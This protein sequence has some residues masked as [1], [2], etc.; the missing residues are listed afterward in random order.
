M[1]FSFSIMKTLWLPGAGLWGTYLFII[2][3]RVDA[4]NYTR[5]NRS[6]LS[7]LS[8]LV[9]LHCSSW[10]FN[11]NA[12]CFGPAKLGL[13]PDRN[14][15]T[16]RQNG[17]LKQWV[18]QT[19]ETR[20]NLWEVNTPQTHRKQLTHIILINAIR[21]HSRTLDRWLEWQKTSTG[22]VEMHTTK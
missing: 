11:G 6:F 14:I 22:R 9:P 15:L 5:L 19:K 1:G 13:L 20:H 10:M 18:L 2:D 21:Y 3:R 7:D 12:G 17:G 4:R 8:V 16:Q